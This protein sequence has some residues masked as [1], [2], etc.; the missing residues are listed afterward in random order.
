MNCH[1]WF[2]L[3]EKR[4]TGTRL[5]LSAAGQS[6][7]WGKTPTVKPLASVTE[8]CTFKQIISNNQMLAMCLFPLR[9]CM[10]SV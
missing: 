5:T 4:V 6:F 2:A 7:S 1:L 10:V 8:L 3:Q 9:M